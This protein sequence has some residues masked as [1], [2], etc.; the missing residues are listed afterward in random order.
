MKSSPPR[1]EPNCGSAFPVA[2]LGVL[3]IVAGVYHGNGFAVAFG[4]PLLL[5]PIALWLMVRHALARVRVERAVPSAVF[6]GEDVNVTIS[7]ENES[8]LPI[9]YPVVT[10][11]FT[12]ELHSRKRVTFPFRVVG[13]ERVETTYRGRCLLPRGVYTLGSGIVTLSDPFGLIQM[14]KKLPHR[15]QLKVYPVVQRFGIEERLGAIISA[16]RDDH[17]CSRIGES[18]DFFSVRDYRFGDPIRKIHWPLTAHRGSPVVREFTRNS[19]G[20]LGIFVDLFRPALIGIGRGSSLEH[21][22][23]MTVA[24]AGRALSRGMRV[25]VFARGQ[26]VGF[27]PGGSGAAQLQAVLDLVVRMR[28][29]GAVSLPDLFTRH[30]DQLRAGDCVF[31]TASPYLFSSRALTAR[32]RA[33]RARGLRVV[34]AVFDDTSFR[35]LFHGDQPA[36]GERL[37]FTSRLR[38]L[39]VEVHEVACGTDLEVVFRRRAR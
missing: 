25:G 19:I 5:G 32:V 26:R 31:F 34:A 14:S 6:E 37:A 12:P 16:M 4:T 27:L 30:D 36:I 10:D 35:A 2:A 39:G 11:V 24:I 20:S 23:K 3:A 15:D 29:D 17:T 1:A 8:R 28:P 21:A 38:S 18:L 7:L 13:G 22:V 9:F 33:L